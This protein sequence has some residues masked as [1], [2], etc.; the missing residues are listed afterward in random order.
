MTGLAGMRLTII[1]CSG[2]FPG[3]ESPASCYLVE[4]ETDGR[5]WRILLDLGNGAL[6]YLQKY[7]DPLDIDAVLISHLHADHCLDLCGYYVF[8]KYHPA[9]DAPRV[10]VW[11]PEGTAERMARAY[12]LP[13]DP[14]MTEEFD[15]RSYPSASFRVG[16][17]TILALRVEHPVVAYAL[18]IAA[19]GRL[20]TYSGDTGPCAA[21]D[22]AAQHADLLLAEASFRDGDNN[23]SAVHLTGKQC[24]ETA[25]KAQ[26]ARLVLTHIPPWHEPERSRNEALSTYLGPIEVATSGAIFVI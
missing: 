17:F 25:T 5:C 7:V 9:G 22:R 1:G 18:R 3:P 20:L 21:L 13:I 23:P 12:D 15:F 26:A 4:A 14:G 10:Q 24:G 11:G 19:N 8:R 6:G 2:S 16:P